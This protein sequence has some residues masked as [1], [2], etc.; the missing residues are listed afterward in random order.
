MQKNS[1]IY[2]SNSD[3][4]SEVPMFPCPLGIFIWISIENRIVQTKTQLMTVFPLICL[5][6]SF[7]CLAEEQLYP[8]CVSV[9]NLLVN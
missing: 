4:S 2:I 5:V 8:S 9:P 1:K 7:L 6:H 3:I